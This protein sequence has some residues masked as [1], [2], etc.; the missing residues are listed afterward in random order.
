MT[1][2]GAAHPVAA[3]P[4]RDSGPSSSPSAGAA[5]PARTSASGRPRYNG[6]IERVDAPFGVAF[7]H[8]SRKIYVTESR[9]NRIAVFDRLGR[10]VSTFGERVLTRPTAIAFDFFGSVAV[11]SAGSREIALF[12]PGGRLITKFGV[13]AAAPLGLA[14]D[15]PSRRL[16]V[17]DT[18]ANSAWIGTYGRGFVR[19]APNGLR[20]PGGVAAAGGRFLIA[21]GTD[22][23]LFE[24]SAA[25][26]LIRELSSQPATQP[27]GVTFP[28]FGNGVLLTSRNESR[29][30]F[31]RRVG[32]PLRPFGGRPRMTRPMLPGSECSR[33]A[34][35]DLAG[36]R[37]VAYDLPNAGSCVQALRLSRAVTAPDLSRIALTVV[38][39]NDGA[40]SVRSRIDVRSGR[41]VKRFRTRLVKAALIAARKDKVRV[42]I[43]RRAARALRRTLRRGRRAV[44]RLRFDVSN[45]AGSKR[46][47]SARLVYRRGVLGRLA[48]ARRSAPP[49]TLELG[50]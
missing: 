23:R 7:N 36:N 31:A 10:R 6:T 37:V 26:K 9:R 3:A 24:L 17:T 32:H 11:L 2:G 50:R 42:A 49:T 28:P 35:P 21:A 22:G 45:R 1:T 15:M 16:L 30:L 20:G 8:Y 19:V 18:F 34:F 39:E 13:P 12:T 29:A 5:A 47:L 48:A 4:L 33:A 43:P 27:F 40:V 44:V 25:G 38:A 14:Y 46:R 41:G